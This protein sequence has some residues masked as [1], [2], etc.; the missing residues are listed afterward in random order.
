MTKKF[1]VLKSGIIWEVEEGSVAHK[2]MAALPKEYELV[3]DNSVIQ[4]NKPIIQTEPTSGPEPETRIESP[5]VEEK[6]K[7]EP[8]SK[9]ERKGGKR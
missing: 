5:A 9:Y 3:D 4:T 1:K 6:T 8:D 7:Y 2:R